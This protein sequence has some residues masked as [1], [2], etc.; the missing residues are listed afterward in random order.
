MVVAVIAVR[1]VE[2]EVAIDNVVDD[3]V[4]RLS[5]LYGRRS[6]RREGG[7]GGRRQCRRRRG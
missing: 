3:E 2:V 1:V 5:Q 6:D 4:S 7:G